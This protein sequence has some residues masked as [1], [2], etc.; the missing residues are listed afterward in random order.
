M[1]CGS[2]FLLALPTRA[3]RAVRRRPWA[4]L[5]VALAF[6]AAAAAGGV[7]WHSG[8]QMEA[9]RTALAHD[10]P[11][12]ALEHLDFCL[13]V[14]PRNSESHRLAARAYRIKGNLTAAEEQ[15]NR[16]LEL[17]GG[18]T[19]AVK[20]EFLLIRVQ[21][22]E[23]DELAEALFALTDDGHPD[24]PAI[25]QTIAC[26]YIA[27]LR[28]APAYQCLTYWIDHYPQDARPYKWRG[29]VLERINMPG[30]ALRDYLQALERDP[31][32]LEV[33]LRVVEM[34]LEDKQAPEAV[35]HLDVLLRQA[36]DDPRVKARV[37]MCRFQQGRAGEARRLMEEAAPHMPKDAPLLITLARLDLQDG[38]A[39]D[40]ER[41]LRTV[42]QTDPY[43]P[44][45]LFVL[46][47]VLQFQGRTEEAVAALAD[48]EKYQQVVDRINDSLKDVPEDPSVGAPRY[49]EL[50]QLFLQIG[51]EPFAVHWLERA[52]EGDPAN[53]T[54][55]RLLAEHYERG[56]DP[57]VA[58][59]HREQLR[60]PAPVTPPPKAPQP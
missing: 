12:A 24:S 43:D 8:R 19:E 38:R 47:S 34:Y 17:D 45:A 27:R 59:A 41:R 42:L 50:A 16:C 35:P 40:A 23:M 52:L 49:V 25:L 30:L 26:S 32:L 22:G 21:A 51:R 39:D 10:Q 13:R 48:H 31:N 5:V 28:Y 20:L 7:W 54:A 55:H 14:W 53:Q 18:A 15:L 11:D 1:A 6:S 9:A 29:W 37:G 2:R 36:P 3:A 58:A 44:E 4:A 60:A 33:R 57:R 46:A 56:G